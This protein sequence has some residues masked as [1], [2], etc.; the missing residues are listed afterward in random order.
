MFRYIDLFCGIGGFHQGVDRVSLKRN[1]ESKCLFAADNDFYAA[2]V[3]ENNYRISALYDLT[4]EETH[5]LIDDAIGNEGLTCMLAG[6]PCQPFSK[7]GDR[8]GFDNQLKGTL[9]FELVKIIE[10]HKPNIVLLENVRN[11]KNHDDGNTWGTIKGT[12]EKLGYRIES[13]IL[14]PNNIKKIPALRE[15][16]FILAFRSDILINDRIPK[17]AELNQRFL[18]T[19]IFAHS[20]ITRGLNTAFFI[21]NEKSYIDPRKIEIIEMWNE[22]FHLLYDSGKTLISPLWP[23]YFDYIGNDDIPAWKMKIIKKN[24]EWYSSNKEIYDSWYSKNKD[25]FDSLKESSKKFEW[26]ARNEISD[27]WEGIIQFRPS[28]VR[29]KKSDF[30]PT[31]VAINQTPILGVEKRYILP[32]EISRIYG[33]KRL[34]FGDQPQKESYKQLGNTVS[35]DVVEHLLEYMLNRI[36]YGGTKSGEEN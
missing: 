9:F 10:K 23:K 24:Q 26:N 33:F 7:A 34:K 13:T 28:G 27:I 25:L 16:F 22:L 36:N 30:I 29:V 4:K 5:K 35:V 12:L 31:L 14:S 1:F 21:K 19:S 6:F 3:Y 18:D 15:R 11:L 2:K 32:E 20:K 17:I 8:Q